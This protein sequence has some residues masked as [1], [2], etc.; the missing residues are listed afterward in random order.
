MV[1]LALRGGLGFCHIRRGHFY[2]SVSRLYGFST[3]RSAYFGRCLAQA[4]R[5]AEHISHLESGVCQIQPE[6][7]VLLFCLVSLGF[8]RCSLANIQSDAAG[9]IALFVVLC[10]LSVYWLAE[11]LIGSPCSKSH[12]KNHNT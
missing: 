8:H 2:F 11:V 12:R 7:L 3:L 1:L 4:K 9:I 6:T 5:D 10:F